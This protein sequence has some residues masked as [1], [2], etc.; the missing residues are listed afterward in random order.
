MKKR[1]KE[2]PEWVEYT[3]E[4]REQIRQ[5]TYKAQAKMREEGY[6][7]VENPNRYYMTG[8]YTKQSRICQVPLI[9]I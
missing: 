9:F 7:L 6:I 3:D 1:R 4:L 5:S 8:Y 2:K